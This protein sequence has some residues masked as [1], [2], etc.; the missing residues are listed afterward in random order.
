MSVRTR[1]RRLRSFLRCA[2][3]LPVASLLPGGARCAVGHTVDDAASPAGASAIRATDL[4]RVRTVAEIDVSIDGLRAIA[5][6]RSIHGSMTDR[7]GGGPAGSAAAAVVAPGDSRARGPGNQQ[8][9]F[10]LE[11][12]RSEPR[13]VQLTFGDR[14][15]THARLSPDGRQVAFLRESDPGDTAVEGRQVWILP[16]D[17]GGEAR[18][19][20]A[21]PHGVAALTWSP[22]G[23]RLLLSSD[24]PLH[25]LPVPTTWPTERPGE[26][27]A[28]AVGGTADPDGTPAEARAW[29]ERNALGG[30]PVVMYRLDFQDERALRPD[31]RVRTLHLVDADGSPSTSSRVSVAARDHRDAVYLPDGSAVLYIAPAD[32]AVHPDR[33]QETVIRRLVPATGRDEVALRLPGWTLRQPKPSRDGLVVALLG[34]PVDEPAYRLAQLGVATISASGLGMPV[35]LTEDATMTASIRAF[36]WLPARS[37]LVFTM[38][39]RGAI[40]LLVMGFGLLE[41]AVLVDSIGGLPAQIGAIGAGAGTT[42]YAASTAANPAVIRVNDARGDRPAVDL[43]PWIPSRRLSQ[44]E[45]LEVR[46]PD[47]TNVEGWY[48]PPSDTGPPGT[49]TAVNAAP[50]PLIVQIHGGPAVMWGPAEPTMWHEWQCACARG[51]AVVFCNPRGST[52]YGAAFQRLNRQDWAEGP[53]GDVLAIVDAAMAR[54]RVDPA[55]LYLTGGSYGGFLTAAIIARD[56]RFRAAVAQRGVYDLHTFFGEGN[57]FRL[58]ERAFGGPPWDPPVR[59][60]LRRESPLSQVTRM[61]TPLLIMHGSSDLRTGVSQSEMLYRSLKVLDRPV[62]YVRYPGADHDLSRRGDPLQR[63]D[64]VLRIIEFFDRHGGESV[65]R[66]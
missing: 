59:A 61:R 28:G 19:V 16:L 15:D 27:G 38:A 26:A 11:P 45:R 7:L 46:R 42:V 5:S 3:L 1:S 51:Y 57:A 48:M 37:S 22:D 65:G 25:A 47:G 53:A 23:R 14:R 9:L 58:V 34:S 17:G 32:D 63:L 4:F 41:P 64:R 62:E 13:W 44:P 52:G 39:R 8:H 40:P 10:L 56:N 60:I 29:L 2:C 49:D 24:E 20:S 66:P 6:V 12:G 18:R 55:R 31:V 50:P 33:Q 30:D 43:N 36:E 35:W 21:L 54:Y